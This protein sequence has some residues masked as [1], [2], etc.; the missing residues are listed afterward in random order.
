MHDS[1]HWWTKRINQYLQ[2]NKKITNRLL[3]SSSLIIDCLALFLVLWSL[4]GPS[5]RPFVALVILFTSR[6]LT[7]SL[8]ALPIP[9]GMIWHN[10]GF[11]SLLV[12]YEVANDLFFSGHT[13]IAVLGALEL[14]AVSQT[15]NLPLLI[16]LAIGIMVFEIA[17]VLVLRAHWT[18][19]VICGAFAAVAIH[20]F[21]VHF[22]SEIDN[23]VNQIQNWI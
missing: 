1:V 14:L 10:P 12:T 22:Q 19:D 17:T 21:S 3:I 7:Q 8:A 23:I 13:A 2:L 20:Y 16:P 15:H 5:F 18:I 6:Q 9:Q 4:L 11:P